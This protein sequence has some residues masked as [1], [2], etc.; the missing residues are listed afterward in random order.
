METKRCTRCGVEKPLEMFCKDKKTK[1]GLNFWCR[2][3]VKKYLESIKDKKREMD[4]R[5][6]EKNKEKMSEYQK[7]YRKEN[8]ERL[9]QKAKEYRENN[10]EKIALYKKEHSIK[11][12]DKI[13]K[14]KK[15]YIEK[16]KEKIAKR[17]AEYYIKNREMLLQ[18]SREYRKKRKKEDYIFRLKEDIRTVIR[19]SF[20][21]KGIKKSKKTEQIIGCTIT[22]LKNHLLQTFF[23]NY[24]YEWDGVEDVHI[25]HIVPLATVNTE[26]E[27]M[28]LCHYSNLQLL[29]AKD[30]M[31]KADKLDFELP[32]L[33]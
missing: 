21:R 10:K 25:D 29:K 16:N 31:E 13:A 32:P 24:G 2:E 3:C 20:K 30:N 28:K 17:H 23:E 22:E 8:K 6:R 11:N 12:K 33:P 1:D 15:E 7:K 14:K 18:K 19:H 9:S 5:Y 26:E 4:K 27:V